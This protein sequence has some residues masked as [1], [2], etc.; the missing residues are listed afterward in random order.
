MLSWIHTQIAGWAVLPDFAVVSFGASFL[1]VEQSMM[2]AVS[3]KLESFFCLMQH[4]PP[5]LRLLTRKVS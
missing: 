1:F 3:S 5:S 2:F 4:K